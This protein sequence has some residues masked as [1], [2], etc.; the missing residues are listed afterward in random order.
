MPVD[1]STAILGETRGMAPVADLQDFHAGLSAM[2]RQA[3]RF[4]KIFSQS[5]SHD[6]Y[7]LEGFTSLLSATITDRQKLQVRILIRDT[8]DIVARG[9]RIVALHHRLPSYVAIHRFPDE[10]MLDREEYVLFDDTGI[11]KRYPRAEMKGYFEFRTTDAAIKARQ[12]DALWERSMP[13]QDIQ[14]VRV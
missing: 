5:L 13:C 8:A 10:A 9:H 6:L 7:D 11:I 4:V 2:A 3:Q 12:F 1:P 14:A